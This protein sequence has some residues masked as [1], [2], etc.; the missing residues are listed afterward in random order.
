M[1]YTDHHALV[2]GATGLAGLSL[3]QSWPPTLQPLHSIRPRHSHQQPTAW[4]TAPT[5]TGPMGNH[6][7]SASCGRPAQ[8]QLD[9]PIARQGRRHWACHARLLL[10]LVTGGVSPSVVGWML[11]GRTAWT[12]FSQCN[13]VFV[14]E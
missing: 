3:P 7:T 13:H 8:R 6:Q 12:V 5:P 10:W 9:G 2:F 4:S 1:P 11:T 14:R